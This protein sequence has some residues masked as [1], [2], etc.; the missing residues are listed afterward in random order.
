ML[1]TE[2]GFPCEAI[3]QAMSF[4]LMPHSNI[5]TT[6]H[7]SDVESGT[8]FA[9][10]GAAWSGRAILA[11][12]SVKHLKKNRKFLWICMHVSQKID[13]LVYIFS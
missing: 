2:T 3:V 4:G 1:R 5:S 7:L 10:V 9:L 13:E 8:T 6:S 11:P 12:L